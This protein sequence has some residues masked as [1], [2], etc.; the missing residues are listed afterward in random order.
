MEPQSCIDFI[1]GWCDV[2]EPRNLGKPDRRV[3]SP[4]VLFRRQDEFVR[5]L[6]ACML[7]DANGLVDKSRDMGATWTA[8]SFSDWMWTFQGGSAIGW[9]SN[10]FEQVDKL[11]EP[12]TI[13]EKLRQ[14][15][16]AV[17]DVFRPPVT[18]GVDL[19][20]GI[21]AHPTN[22]SVI[23]GQGGDNIGRGGRKRI[24]FTDEDAHIVDAEAVELSL[25]ENTRCRVAISSAGPPGTVYDRKREAGR[26]WCVGDAVVRDRVNV[27]V[28]DWTDH[29]EKT[30]EW[31]AGRWAFYKSSGMPSV[32]ARE[33]D[34]NPM[35]AQEGIIIAYEYVEAAVDAHR[36][37]GF[38]D[39]GGWWGGQDVADEGVDMNAL[40]RG[41]G[42]VAKRADEWGQSRD[43]G[44]SARRAFR[45][46]RGTSPIELQYDCIGLGTNIKSE[47]NRLTQDE[48]VDTSWLTLT[49]WNA[50]AKVL[51]PGDR[52]IKND[53]QSP[54]NKNYFENFK[55]QAWWSVEQ[56]FRKTWMCVEAA[57]DDR[58]EVDES[59]AETFYLVT[60]GDGNVLR[61]GA[62]ELISLDSSSIDDAL[63]KKLMR[64]L[65][66]A[67]WGQSARLKQMVNKA[68]KGSKSPNLA[69]A[70]VMGRFPAPRAR[71]AAG[72]VSMFGPKVIRG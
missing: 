34:R 25:S 38:E 71:G 12:D 51:S 5:F 27:F 4:M 2:Y 19:K 67:T 72:A 47:F 35:G 46:C 6:F 26:E 28:M 18:R 39:D 58:L 37:L 68:P 23:S 53:P 31:Y 60:D 3:R 29:P 59:A 13:F 70:L 52:V 1:N 61:Y 17:P 69:D 49:P 44:E 8:L 30:Q 15:I 33:I 21:C 7:G 55:A 45:L 65:S 42:V 9:G 41:R 11:K 14:Q 54:T 50:G 40:V 24:V 32:V 56:M 43:P 36:V 64:E 63:L 66:Q 62:G 20:L 16:L 48:S 22:G 10:K 57:K